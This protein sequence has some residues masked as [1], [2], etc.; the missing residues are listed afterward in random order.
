MCV[1]LWLK[2]HEC[3]AVS[4]ICVCA[5][6]K[7][8]GSGCFVYQYESGVIQMTGQCRYFVYASGM[9]YYYLVFIS[10]CTYVNVAVLCN[11][12]FVAYI[13]FHYDYFLCLCSLFV[14]HLKT[15]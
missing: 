15:S 3:V 4:F 7:G 9:L 11:I 12:F 14:C 6:P 13:A 8:N 2:G 10:I 5:S 1:W